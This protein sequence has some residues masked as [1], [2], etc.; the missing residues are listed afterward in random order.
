MK[1]SAI[2]P[3]FNSASLVGD[4]IDRTVGFFVGERLDYELVL[5]DDGS[6]DESLAVLRRKARGQPRFIV[7]ALP[8]NGGQHRALVEGLRRATGDWLVTLDDDLQNPPE[9]I[10]ALIAVAARGHDVVFGRFRRKRHPAP[11][12]AASRL[13]GLVNRWLF[14]KPRGLVVSNFRLLHRDVVTKILADDSETPYLTGQALLHARSPANA[15]VRHE[16]RR[17]GRSGYGVRRSAR[18]LLEIFRHR[19]SRRKIVPTRNVIPATVIGK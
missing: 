11:K 12:R 14:H 15:D 7:V 9:E 18:F 4:T 1:Y 3:V 17:N 2:I 10:G 16:P 8:R 19:L 6:S 5:V 13:V